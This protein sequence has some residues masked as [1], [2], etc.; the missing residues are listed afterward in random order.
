M[1]S[2]SFRDAVWLSTLLAS[3]SHAGQPSASTNTPSISQSTPEFIPVPTGQWVSPEYKW[4]FQYPLPIP[5]IKTPTYTYSNYSTGATIDYYEVEIKP[6]KAQIYPNLPATDMVGYDGC[7]PGPMFV[8]QQG[9]EVVTRFTNNGPSASSVHLH[10][11]YNRAPFDGWAGD[12]ISPGQYKARL[13]LAK[14]T[15]RAV[16]MVPC[17]HLIFSKSFTDDPNYGKD[18]VEFATGEHVYRGQGGIYLL[19][20]PE[21]QSIG[22]PAGDY[23][24]PLAIGAKQYNSDG[25]LNWDTNDNN[26]LWGDIIHV[27]GQPWP[28]FKAEPRKYRFRLLNGAVSRTF[29]LSWVPD[30]AFG[31][32]TDP[33]EFNV[34]GSDSGLLPHPVK[35]TSLAFSMGERYEIVIDFSSYAG[36]NI[37]IRNDRHIGENPDY[38]ATDFIMRIAVGDTVTDDS[39]NSDLPYNLRYIPPPPQTSVS[40]DFMFER[41]GDN[42]LINGVG[43][44]DINH[45]IL[46]KPRRGEDEI[47]VLRNGPGGGTHPVHIHLVDFQVLS[48]SGGR[49]VLYAYESTGM[50]DVVWLSAGEAVTVVARYAPWEGVYMFHCH[51]LVHEDHDMLVA[52]NVTQ[53]PNWGY[54][55]STIFIDPLTPEFRPKDINSEDYTKDAIMSKLAWFYSTNAY[56]G[57]NVAGVYSALDGYEAGQTPALASSSEATPTFPWSSPQHPT[58]FQTLPSH[59]WSYPTTHGWPKTD[60]PQ[61]PSTKPQ[62]GWSP[63]NFEKW[64]NGP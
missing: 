38:A 54:D 57:G 44:V 30:N 29:G 31:F 55:N 32:G 45:R 15:K 19:R 26:G 52:F 34:I 8:V 47:W 10:G 21:E 42:W 39:N 25:S 59:S 13:L 58:T 37:T 62:S 35:A 9:R 64:I 51:N 63:P 40:K 24:I 43:F 22:L 5:S 20:D 17:E 18:H 27:N 33:I 46:A 7:S 3:Y 14:S 6:F 50:K 11:S 48:R 41:K 12:H 1:Y 2:I 60:M 53:L 61:G 36:K 49:N 16:N 23:D 4:F 28:Y 56:N